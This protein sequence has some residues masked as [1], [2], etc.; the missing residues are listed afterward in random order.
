MPV[1]DS[2]LS[3]RLQEILDAGWFE[4]PNIAGYGGTGGPGKVLEE[5]LELNN[6][7][8]DTPDAGRWE[9]KFHSGTALLT[10]F[11]KEARPKRHLYKLI[12]DFGI[13][14]SRTRRSFRHTIKGK[15]PKG[16]KVINREGRIIVRH[17]SLD[18]SEWPYWT[19]D[20]LI[21]AFASKL[22]RL[23]VVAGL[24]GA[25]PRRVRYNTA[26]L[27]WEPQITLL[28]DAIESGIVAIDFDA[29]TTD[30]KGLRNHGTKFRIKYDDLQHIYHQHSQFEKQSSA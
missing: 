14:D 15:S 3:E 4:I 8:F 23:I 11:H 17:K 7:N 24:K 28:A 18:E 13:T 22:R 6:S 20:T 26:H 5:L 9:I 29:R 10:L 30:G 21:N 25:N 2:D 1:S 19:H 12:Q 16:F 27:F